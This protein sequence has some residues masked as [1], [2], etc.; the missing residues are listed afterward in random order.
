MPYFNTVIL[1]WGF[2]KKAQPEETDTNNNKRQNQARVGQPNAQ[3]WPQL[4]KD[5]L[6]MMQTETQSDAPVTETARA[7]TSTT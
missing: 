1:K 7:R 4:T 5:K 6:T 2:L 3:T